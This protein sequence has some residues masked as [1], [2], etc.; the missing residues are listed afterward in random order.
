MSGESVKTRRF[1]S[2]RCLVY[3][4]SGRAGSAA[5]NRNNPR[6]RNDNNGFRVLVVHDSR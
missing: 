1:D 5:R 3:Y 2:G 6:N 4:V